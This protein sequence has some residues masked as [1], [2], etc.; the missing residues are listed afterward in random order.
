ML[1]RTSFLDVH[2]MEKE[3]KTAVKKDFKTGE[4]YYSYKKAMLISS[5]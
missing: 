5:L 2:R 1:I 3:I 4:S